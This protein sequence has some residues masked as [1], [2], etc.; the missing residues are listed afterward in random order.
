MKR[1]IV[2]LL[3]ALLSCAFAFAKLTGSAGVKFE[4]NIDK[5]TLSTT[6]TTSFNFTYTFASD[7]VKINSKED[8]HVEVAATA[9]F[10][11]GSRI[12]GD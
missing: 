3:I 8:V 9:K 4:E 2:V 10:I 6:N 7:K 11:L 12:K 5:E 1:V